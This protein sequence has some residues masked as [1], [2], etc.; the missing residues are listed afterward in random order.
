MLKLAQINSRTSLGL[1]KYN[2]QVTLLCTWLCMS[3]T[4]TSALWPLHASATTVPHFL[5]IPSRPKT[6]LAQSSC[7]DCFLFLEFPQL[8]LWTSDVFSSFQCEV[9]SLF[10]EMISDFIS[11]GAS[12]LRHYSTLLLY[13]NVTSMRAASSW[14]FCCTVLTKPRVESVTKKRLPNFLFHR[15]Q[16]V[17]CKLLT[18]LLNTLFY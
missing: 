10:L 15:F 3:S 7:T 16:Q 13:I 11:R 1:L 18:N 4:F 17:I 6:F 8:A 5:L 9:K 2:P 14:V 12:S